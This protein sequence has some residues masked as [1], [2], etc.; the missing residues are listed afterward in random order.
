[1]NVTPLNGNVVGLKRLAQEQ[2]DE[3]SRKKG[4]SFLGPEL[5]FA[6][7]TARSSLCNQT[8]IWGNHARTGLLIF[9]ESQAKLPGN[10]A[11]VLTLS[12][13]NATLW[14]IK[15]RG[16]RAHLNLGNQT[17]FSLERCSEEALFSKFMLLGFVISASNQVPNSVSGVTLSVAR[18]MRMSVVDIWSH[19]VNQQFLES[20]KPL[21]VA[22]LRLGTILGYGLIRKRC[23]ETDKGEI[24]MYDSE[25]NIEHAQS[26]HVTF[27]DRGYVYQLEPVV[28]PYLPPGTVF[29]KPVAIVVS[30]KDASS[31]PE[32]LHLRDGWA[33]PTG[34]V[35]SITVNVDISMR[36]GL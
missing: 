24:L 27:E 20:A 33:N 12:E 35:W 36:D 31:N 29:S 32:P 25:E 4:K 14:R 1:M 21:T 22:S 2:A 10:Q 26:K 19:W 18:I 3:E 28:F 11:P 13:I 15:E 9:T 17:P 23:F 16:E 5:S 7:T 6:V 8:Q 34:I 30:A